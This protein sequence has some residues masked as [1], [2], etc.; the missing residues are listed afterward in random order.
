MTKKNGN[1][2][3]RGGFFTSGPQNGKELPKRNPYPSVAV[4]PP[5]RASHTFSQQSLIGNAGR[6]RRP[7]QPTPLPGH[8]RA[9][10][11]QGCPHNAGTWPRHQGAAGPHPPNARK[12]TAHVREKRH[13]PEIKE[14]RDKPSDAASTLEEG[15]QSQF[16]G[17]RAAKARPRDFGL[18]MR[19]AVN[20][21]PWEQ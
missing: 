11:D 2:T 16:A 15:R 12:Q 18:K 13:M 9:R 20:R 19:M 3:N 5:V 1:D 10:F 17:G 7:Q 8:Y 4:T 14:V 21:L 6:R